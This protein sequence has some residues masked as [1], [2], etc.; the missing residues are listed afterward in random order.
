[1]TVLKVTSATACVFAGRILRC[2]IGR[3]GVRV[4]KRE[5]DGAAPAGVWPMRRVLY[6]PDRLA[7]PETAL[8][9]GSITETDGWCDDAARPEYNRPVT[10][11]FAGSH[12]VMWRKDHLYD[13][14]VVLG[15]N[16][17]PPVPGLGS[18]VF[19]HCAHEDYAPTEGCV[20]LARADLLDVLKDCGLKSAVA[21]EPTAQT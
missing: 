21:V 8:P 9:A 5:G 6:R 1:M 20:A 10:L 12:E 7:A 13:V 3:G 4:D 18:A 17:S 2:A 16:D 15:H 19:L 11:P 14:V